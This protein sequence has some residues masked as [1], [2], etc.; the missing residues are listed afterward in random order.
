M[1]LAKQ[2]NDHWKQA[3]QVM[4]LNVVEGK[5]VSRVSQA[6]TYT[7]PKKKISVGS[8]SATEADLFYECLH[9]LLWCYKLCARQK[10]KTRWLT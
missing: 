3:I 6:G 5:D 4:R 1:A 2:V 9:A 10:V 7:S 8:I